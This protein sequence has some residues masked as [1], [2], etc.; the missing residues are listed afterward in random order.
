MLIPVRQ[1]FG[2]RGLSDVA[3]ET[4]RVLAESRFG[5]RLKPGSRVAIGAGSRGISNIA[6]I[7]RAVADYFT[8]EGHRPFIFPAMGSHGAATAAGQASVLAHYGIDESRMGCPVVS[9]FDVISLGHTES[10]IE[11]FAGKDAWASDGIFVINRVK[12]HTSF[13][14][15][16]ESGVSK[17]LALGLG[18]IQ[19][20]E[21]CH[22]HARRLGMDPVIQS[23]AGRLIGTGKILGGLAIL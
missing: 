20:A 9:S 3:G 16:I 12:W 8:S 7:V 6:A 11:V 15:A 21:T 5:S 2:R 10:G 23:V 1:K 22:G 19:G 17:M 13:D 18:K 4:R 14:G